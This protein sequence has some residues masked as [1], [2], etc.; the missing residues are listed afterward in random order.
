MNSEEFYDDMR[1][2]I[3]NRFMSLSE[4]EQNI[5]RQNIDSEFSKI[6]M[7]VLG[8]DILAGLPHMRRPNE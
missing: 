5:M 6:A 1:Q 2:G 7:K 4:T 8:F 3:I